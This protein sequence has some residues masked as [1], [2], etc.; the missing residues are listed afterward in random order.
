MAGKTAAGREVQTRGRSPV[1]VAMGCLSDG[2]TKGAARALR[3]IGADDP[4]HPE[5][6]LVQALIATGEHRFHEAVTLAAQAKDRLKDPSMA[7]NVLGGGLW[8]LGMYPEALTVL[9]QALD[10]RPDLAAAR[11]NRAVVL[12]EMGRF[13][14]AAA[15][16]KH[17]MDMNDHAVAWRQYVGTRTFGP[18]AP[19][20]TRLRQLLRGKRLSARDRAA[21]QHCIAKIHSDLGRYDAA[22]AAYQAGN[23]LQREANAREGHRFDREAHLGNIR[24]SA[25]RF[26]PELFSGAARPEGQ[27]LS[28]LTICGLPRSGKTVLQQHLTRHPVM[29]SLGERNVTQALARRLGLKGASV[30]LSRTRALTSEQ[31][32]GLREQLDH[33]WERGPEQASVGVTTSPSGLHHVPFL[34]LVSQASRFIWVQRRLDNTALSIY[35]KWFERHEAYA[36]DIDDIA[37]RCVAHEALM[38]HWQ[39]VVPAE[40]LVVRYEDLVENPAAVLGPLLESLDVD[41]HPPCLGEDLPALSPLQVGPGQSLESPTRITAD[42]DRILQHYRQPLERV[43]DALDRAAARLV[44]SVPEL[45]DQVPAPARWRG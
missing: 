29:R 40:I 20:L 31:L 1:D 25:R 39:S 44:K 6:L 15:D 22:F 9:N 38:A 26:T 43:R 35:L 21:Y 18:D 32:E 37:L 42:F 2:D 3:G 10:L 45:T 5:V 14:D 24:R 13:E 7:L 4:R 30:L 19:E 17:L 16:L 27:G 28:V 34:A 33:S 41:P 23:R 11:L 36:C 12:Q 8:K